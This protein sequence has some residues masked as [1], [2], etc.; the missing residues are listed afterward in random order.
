MKK[1]IYELGKLFNRDAI[2]FNFLSEILDGKIKIS[3]SLNNS[4]PEDYLTSVR[5]PESR[6]KVYGNFNISESPDEKILTVR[7]A[8]VDASLK[9][10]LSIPENFHGKIISL[11]R[12]ANKSVEKDFE[13]SNLNDKIEIVKLDP[14]S[15]SV[16]IEAKPVPVSQIQN[17]FNEINSRVKADEEILKYYDGD[18]KQEIQKILGDIKPKLSQAEEKIRSL[19]TAR[20]D[21]TKRI[22]AAVK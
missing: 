8:A 2:K 21:E 10:S 11:Y 22:E 16:K 20:E 6:V 3:F 4:S 1:L 9:I 12:S 15:Y 19:I 13:L 18:I 17:E 7:A 14:E 5:S